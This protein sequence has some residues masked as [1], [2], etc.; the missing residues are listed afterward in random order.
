M[1]L[2]LKNENNDFKPI[3]QMIGEKKNII[4]LNDNEEVDMSGEVMG[5]QK[6]R[7]LKIISKKLFFKG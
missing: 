4:Y 7:K 2:S 3:A 6:L 5:G 1:S